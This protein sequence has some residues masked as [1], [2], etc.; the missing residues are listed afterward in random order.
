MERRSSGWRV[1]HDGCQIADS[2]RGAQPTLDARAFNHPLITMWLYNRHMV[3]TRP[4]ERAD[5]A[6]AAKLFRGLADPMRL[7]I[8]ELLANGEMRVTDIVAALGTSQSNVSAHLA[9][10]KECGLVIDLSL[11]HIS[12]PTRPY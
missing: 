12:E 9:C 1:D 7:A 2:R 5:L 6:V 11:I 4:S 8:V 10:L 3:I